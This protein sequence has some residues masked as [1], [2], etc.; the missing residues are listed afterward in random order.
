MKTN[1]NWFLKV[2]GLTLAF[3]GLLS[4]LRTVSAE[5]MVS[6]DNLVF[7]PATDTAEELAYYSI[8]PARET[9]GELFIEK[10]VNIT[11]F[12][13]GVEQTL[14]FLEFDAGWGFLFQGLALEYEVYVVT[15]CGMYYFRRTMRP[16][17]FLIEPLRPVADSPTTAPTEP[18]TTGPPATIPTDPPATE[19][20]TTIPPVDSPTLP[21][22]LPRPPGGINRPPAFPPSTTPPTIPP[23]TP[24]VDCPEVCDCSITCDC[25][26]ATIPPVSSAPSIPGAGGGN[27]NLPQTGAVA[28]NIGLAGAGVSTLGA[29]AV[30]VKKGKK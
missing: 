11:F 29:I 22:I 27:N 8:F 28:L 12:Y 24:D 6:Y 15:F 20:P 5:G 18:P 26:I 17:T 3:V 16:N 23:S 25:P 30:F 2:F 13:G 10:N 19:P 14:E 21:P 4:F 1:K 9:F 7:E